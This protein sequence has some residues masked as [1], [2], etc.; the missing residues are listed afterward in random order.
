MLVLSRKPEE[1]IVITVGGQRVIVKVV[2]VQG[3]NVRLG[4]DASK[5]VRID[6]SEIDERR[7][8]ETPRVPV[9]QPEGFASEVQMHVA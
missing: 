5:D 8:K 2:R 4:F 9:V 7:R 1:S 3:D 6:R